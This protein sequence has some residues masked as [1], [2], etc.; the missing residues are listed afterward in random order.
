MLERER[1]TDNEWVGKGKRKNSVLR[2][3]WAQ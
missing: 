1:Q 3:D 2:F